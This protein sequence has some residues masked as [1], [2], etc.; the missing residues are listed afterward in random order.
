M[1]ASGSQSRRH[2][3]LLPVLALVLGVAAGGPTQRALAGAAP[4]LLAHLTN[5][6]KGW[7][8]FEP[9]PDTRMIFVS[10]SEGD[11]ANDGLSPDRPLK[12]IARGVSLL[13]DGYPDWLLLK[14]GDAWP[15]NC[16]WNRSGRPGQPNLLGAYGQGPRPVVGSGKGSAFST[17]NRKYVAVVG[18]RFDGRGSAMIG[19][20]TL[21]N[22]FNKATTDWLVEDCVVTGFRIGMHLSGEGS[23]NVTLRRCILTDNKGQGILGKAKNMVIE[24]CLLDNNGTSATRDHNLYLAKH[25]DLTIRGC[26]LSNGSDAGAKIQ[27][28]TRGKVQD[29]L[30]FGNGSAASP[31]CNPDPKEPGRAVI[32]L[33]FTGN[34]CVSMGSRKDHEGTGLYIWANQ[35]CTYRDNLFV[36]K[37]NVGDTATPANGNATISIQKPFYNAP[38]AGALKGLVIEDNTFYDWPGVFLRFGDWPREGVQVRRNLF[39]TPRA[40]PRQG[41][42]IEYARTS[43]KAGEVTFAEN[44]YHIGNAP[45]E[46]WFRNGD[47]DLSLAD[48]VSRPHPHS[49]QLRQVAGRS[50]HARALH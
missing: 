5:P 36:N 45:A 30:F 20:S 13:R 3:V 32:D 27:T 2:L 44:V 23:T 29:N 28:L 6:G 43:W 40:S 34:V 7:T 21:Q 1:K 18:I 19:L 14:R 47:R 39:Q 10:N 12:T 48:W 46:A 41:R 22:Q 31:N 16:N 35:N 49:R 9:A 25:T 50:G 38:H 4:E 42:A 8:A 24:Q 15:E 11:D 26:I 17:M 33:E 37:R